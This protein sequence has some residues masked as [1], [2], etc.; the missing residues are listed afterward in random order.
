MGRFSWLWI[1]RLRTLNRLRR[2]GGLVLVVLWVRLEQHQFRKSATS[3]LLKNL[4]ESVK[5]SQNVDG[6]LANKILC[7]S[8]TILLHR[9]QKLLED[10]HFWNNK[11]TSPL[12]QCQRVNP[13]MDPHSFLYKPSDSTCS[14]SSLC[15]KEWC[16]QRVPR[17][18]T[19]S[20]PSSSVPPRGS[21]D[22]SFFLFFA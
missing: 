14:C 9:T 5:R 4:Y 17:T 1:L 22:P 11:A 10:L 15:L 16:A 12:R 21:D 6:C 7:Q 13:R 18:D 20:S 2:F 8:T 19:N 3:V